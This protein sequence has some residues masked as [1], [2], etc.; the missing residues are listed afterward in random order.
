MNDIILLFELRE[1]FVLTIQI[2][3]NKHKVNDEHETKFFLTFLLEKCLLGFENSDRW[4]TAHCTMGKN[5]GAI[6]WALDSSL[7]LFPFCLKSCKLTTLLT[8]SNLR[9]KKMRN[10]YSRLCTHL[11][12]SHIFIDCLFCK[13]CWFR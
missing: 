4:Q 9:I 3:L 13:I 10:T 7:I 2:R 8:N 11:L 5:V 12:Y 6:D 1:I